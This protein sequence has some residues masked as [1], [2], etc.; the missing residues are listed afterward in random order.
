MSLTELTARELSQ[1]IKARRF[2]CRE[3]M[4]AY[5][6]RIERINPLVNAIVN[7]RDPEILLQRADERDRELADGHWRGVLHGLPQAIKDLAATSDITTTL[8]SPIFKTFLPGED[9][10]HV[11]RIRQAGAIVIGKTNA[12]EFGLGSH[13]FNPL[14]GPTRNPYDLSKSA[15]GSSGGAAAA[16]ATDML[17][18]ADGSDMMGSLRNPAAYNNVIGMRPGIGRVP[19][20]P[21]PEVFLDPM[22]TDGPMGRSVGDVAM[23]LSVQAG[24]DPRAPLSLDG[25]GS[26]FTR[27]L[28]ADM[29]G[30]RIGWLGDLGGHLPFENGVLPLCEA[31]LS[32]F[33]DI[34]CVV[35]E[36]DIGFDMARVWEA[37]VTLR[38]WR[39][40]AKLG[41]HYHDPAKRDLLKDTAIW[42]IENGL[43]LDVPHIQA[44]SE[45]RSAFHRAMLN[46][47]E[48]FDFLILPSAQLFPFDVDLAWPGE[49]AGWTMDTYHRWMEVVVPASLL[50]LPTLAMPAG[51]SGTGLPMGIQ[52]IGSPRADLDVLRIGHAYEQAT[53]WLS[54]KPGLVVD[55]PAG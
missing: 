49:I 18:V 30:K 41:P 1:G 31:A 44:A 47:F 9:S 20:G 8:G 10:I 22:A 39:V 24:Y 36:A 16:L 4:E 46:L 55:K 32:A 29:K 45:V 38:H 50:G 51:F 7:L 23:L 42:E 27:P 28:D 13:T 21:A 3:V 52:I 2:S 40:S 15:G 26:E 11:A 48:S 19:S 17:P 37:W 14:F 34:G 5:L 6:A 33:Q 12:P 43:R 53:S 35:E 54:M 25:D